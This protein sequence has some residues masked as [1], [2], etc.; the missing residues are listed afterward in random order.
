MLVSMAT[1]TF[2]LSPLTNLIRKKLARLPT[3]QEWARLRKYAGRLRNIL[4]FT[5]PEPLQ[6]V[7]S[8]PQFCPPTE[9]L[10]P[11][12]E[13]L[14]LPYLPSSSVPLIPTLLSPRT[15]SINFIF[16]LT[17]PPDCSTAASVIAM[18]PTLCPNLHKI[19]L[20]GLPRD[21]MITLAVSELAKQNTLQY[22][23][24]DSP[25]TVEACQTI[26][27]NPELRVLVQTIVDRPTALPTMVLPN[28]TNLYIECYSSHDWLQV[29][30][31]ASLEKLDWLTISSKSSSIGNFLGAFEAV[32]LTTS[33]PATLSNF[34]FR[35]KCP[36]RPSYRS[37]LPFTQLKCI[38]IEAS[39]EFSC[40]STIDDDTITDLALA[41][42]KLEHLQL[43]NRPCKTPAG[44][45]VKGLA[46]LAFHC[47]RLSNLLIHF[48]V[49]T[50]DPLEIPSLPSA[51]QPTISHE[52]SASFTLDPGFICVP[53]ESVFVV[54]ET[55][56]KLFPHLS[57]IHY[58]YSEDT[59]WEDVFEDFCMLR[60]FRA[61]VLR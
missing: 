19:Q 14:S 43:G 45:T 54:S 28:L 25:L 58:T 56:L 7:L 17:D 8:D 55:L 60:K 39:C 49:A 11:R 2:A 40:S 33:I 18:L 50:L 6:Q 52:G 35:T 42:P 22:F 34:R 61:L 16:S 48:Q 12:L 15:T 32:A 13:V 4:S 51:D 9:P 31:E 44:V 38:I 5:V 30:H 29:F 10:L 27:N 46:A 41:M 21:P 57:H 53:R 1:I 3:V 20:D 37:L 26:Y 36:W 23:N 59:R 47:P 24:A